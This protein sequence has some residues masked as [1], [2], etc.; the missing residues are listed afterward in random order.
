MDYSGVISTFKFILNR[1]DCTDEDAERFLAM[2]MRRVSRKLRTPMQE[3][4]R[5]RTVGPDWN[6]FVVP[7]N[8]MAVIRVE[9]NGEPLNRVPASI[10]GK[11]TSGKP[12][13]Y[14]LEAGVFKFNPEL[15]EGDVVT[16]RYYRDFEEGHATGVLS[17][18]FVYAGL[19][20]AADAYTDARITTWEGYFT[21]L[22]TEVQEL[23]DED[24][25]SG[26]SFAVINPYEGLV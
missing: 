14:S 4:I 2:G 25:R 17:D 15:K 3:A 13:D 10:L 24:A 20:Y 16:L 5:E 12:R 26:Q 1:T 8:F 9:V 11:P 6:G 19:V 7:S 23:A 21:T 22:V 18:M